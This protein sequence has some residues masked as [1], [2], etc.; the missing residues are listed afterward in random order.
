MSSHWPRWGFKIAYSSWTQQRF[1]LHSLK[2]WEKQTMK[3]IFGHFSHISTFLALGTFLKELDSCR[4]VFA[5]EDKSN[6]RILF[7]LWKPTTA[8]LTRSFLRTGK[9]IK[10]DHMMTEIAGG[11]NILSGFAACKKC[12]NVRTLDSR[13]LAL[14]VTLTAA[15]YRYFTMNT[16]QAPKREDKEDVSMTGAADRSGCGTYADSSRAGLD[17]TWRWL[18]VTGQSFAV[19]G[20]CGFCK[21]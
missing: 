19:V 17:V 13:K 4:L 6:T 14:H 10:T 18:Q 2:K 21:N 1:S 3:G 7:D 12:Q 16:T 15:V 8:N 5:C 11:E 9:P 20:G